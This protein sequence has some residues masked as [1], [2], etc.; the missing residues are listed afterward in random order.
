MVRDPLY[1]S[2]ERRLGER[3]DP[4]LF[5]KCA[6]ELLRD[7]Y[8]G[9]AA[10]AGGDD[11]GMDGAISSGTGEPLPL[12]VT[13]SERVLDN[14]TR[15]LTAYQRTGGSARQ[16]VLATSQALTPRKRRN[17]EKRAR[18][19]GFTLRN[20]HDR[21]DF[22]G[23][24]YRNPMWRKALLDLTGDLPALSA[25]PDQTGPRVR[26]ELVGRDE[27]MGW[28]RAAEG[29]VVVV[30]QPGVGKT[31][32][33]EALAKDGGGLF[34]ILTSTRSR[35]AEASGDLGRIA[36]A[37]RAERPPRIFVDDAHLRGSLVARLARLRD[38]IG[39]KFAIVATTWPSHAGAVGRELY[40]P[41]SRV[42]SVGGLD[43]ESAAR[44]L[45]RVNAGFSDDFIGEI[46]NQ[47]VDNLPGD[48]PLSAEYQ[49]GGHVRPGLAVTL[50]RYASLGDIAKLATG[51]LLLSQLRKDAR[52]NGS[53]L[54]HLATFA[55]GGSA[56]M[57]LAMAAQALGTPETTVRQSLRQVSG[58][59]VV[60]D[61]RGES[62]AI[63][64]R[65]LRHALVRRTFFSGATS[66]PLGTAIDRV[67][68]AVACTET[69]IGVLAREGPSLDKPLRS[70]LHQ[71][72]RTR[73]EKR[74]SPYVGSRSSLWASYAR[75][76]A[77][78]AGWI[79][80]EHP[81]RTIWISGIALRHAPNRFLGRLVAKALDNSQEA[82]ALTKSI[83]AWVRAGR[84]GGDA[85]ERRESLV[86]ALVEQTGG[87]DLNQ[88]SQR[89][90]TE[91]L[92]AA[93][94]LSFHT[95]RDDPIK[96][97]ETS[98]SFSSLPVSDVRK[99]GCFWS[100]ALPVLRGL[101]RSGLSCARNVVHDW[102]I[103]PRVGHEL[104]QTKVAARE[105]V[106]RMLPPVLELA[107]NEPGILLWAHRL[108]N[109]HRLDVKLPEVRNST[110]HQLF[111]NPADIESWE[112][113]RGPLDATARELSRKWLPEGP[114]VIVDRMTYYERQRK[115]MGYDWPN[116]LSRMPRHLAQHVDDPGTW[117]EELVKRDA[118][119]GW[120]DPFLEAAVVIPAASERAWEAVAKDDRY[121]MPCVR[122]GLRVAGLPETI[123]DRIMQ[124]MAGWT[125]KTLSHS[126]DWNTVTRQW[127]HRLLRH[128]EPTVGGAV[129]GGIWVANRRRRPGGRLGTAWEEAV[130]ACG[131]H[132]LMSEVLRS[133]AGI[134]RAWILREARASSVRRRNRHSASEP[135]SSNLTLAE[136]EARPEQSLKEPSLDEELLATAGSSLD[137][138]DRRG[139]I[140]AIPPDANPKFFR[141]LVGDDPDLDTV[142]LRRR[143]GKKA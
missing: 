45:R 66:L 69:L 74:E 118:P 43:R 71:L 137:L 79:L 81:D 34:P 70:Q 33:L 68:N 77:E 96:V 19:L 37:Y 120:V 80:E 124:Q 9:L 101:G 114:A 106:R 12:I 54:D 23:L 30:G 113:S 28:L 29:D 91:L 85:V 36:D 83:C 20:I 140:R 49:S 7:A 41:S 31:A 51:R 58:T 127:K 138:E 35:M 112:W 115:L 134:A 139:L 10:V 65:H 89:M 22:T 90:V 3:L 95:W 53:D 109:E 25:M 11:G 44:V 108:A 132:R 42:L 46:L 75:T 57:R 135:D 21:D 100:L 94:S 18:E 142:L 107:G 141:H 62:V 2:I 78:A 136:R 82:D 117:L 47:S 121:T 111:P 116:A 5:E 55:L 76:G 122:V 15:S 129:A 99:I 87:V 92:A 105:Q 64:P 56:G 32:L 72:I 59:G 17:L 119:P 6:V 26:L 48:D 88:A 52:L 4:N 14:L 61:I 98:I 104:D 133:D 63:H 123:I 110:L 93:F 102:L 50:A 38:E 27:E 24:L 8:P 73:L 131:N 126:I 39:A 125:E 13:T 103:G 1:R 84:P 67:E 16:A 86:R 40:C 130:V 143:A 97:I 60:R 128:P